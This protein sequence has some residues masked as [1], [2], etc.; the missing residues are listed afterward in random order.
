MENTKWHFTE[1]YQ[2]IQNGCL[3]N[4]TVL[5]LDMSYSKLK[6]LVNLQN[7]VNLRVLD[8]SHNKLT[9]LNSIQN[10]TNL[11][12]LFCSRNIITTLSGIQNLVNLQE[13]MYSNDVIDTW[14]NHIE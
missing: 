8:C 12:I 6:S 2:W 1:Y 9:T 3:L 14:I 5:E 7:L 10:L 11:K 4:E 13:L